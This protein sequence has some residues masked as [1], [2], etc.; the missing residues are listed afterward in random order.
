MLTCLYVMSV[1]NPKKEIDSSE[2]LLNRI[3]KIK[4]DF[5]VYMNNNNNNKEVNSDDK[6]D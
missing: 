4:D 1:K 5:N 2:E 3:K 6:S